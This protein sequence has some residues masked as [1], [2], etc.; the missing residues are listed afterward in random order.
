M[1]SVFEEFLIINHENTMFFEKL[2]FAMIADEYVQLRENGV[3]LEGVNFKS[4]IDRVIQWLKQL[5]T[6][7]K[8]LF[9]KFIGLFKKKGKDALKMKEKEEQQEKQAKQQEKTK[10]ELLTDDIPE[11]PKVQK[12]HVE[13]DGP[14]ATIFN[15]QK[16]YDDY[17]NIYHELNSD[18]EARVSFDF[19]D[20]RQPNVADYEELVVRP[21]LRRLEDPKISFRNTIDKVSYPVEDA[22]KCLEQVDYLIERS[23]KTKENLITVIEDWISDLETM[24]GAFDKQVDAYGKGIVPPKEDHKYNPK[25]DY[26]NPYIDY[27]LAKKYQENTYNMIAIAKSFFSATMKIYK[28]QFRVLNRAQQYAIAVVNN[29]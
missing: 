11:P 27:N 20:D 7:M 19:Q 18:T 5:K 23:K 13:L 6:K 3:I 2:K 16:I 4:I 10:K 24:K 29:A 21:I 1:D 12:T 14:L 25:Y 22:K 9:D 8:E 15:V 17:E 26:S 28:E